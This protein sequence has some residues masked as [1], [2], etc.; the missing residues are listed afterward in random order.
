MAAAR[1]AAADLLG[2]VWPRAVRVPIHANI[3]DRR[4]RLCNNTMRLL[5]TGTA[6]FCYVFLFRSYL[7]QVEVIMSNNAWIDAPA[8]LPRVADHGNLCDNRDWDYHYSP[9]WG[10]V[11]N[12]CGVFSTA[13]IFSKGLPISIYWI[14]TY[15]VDAIT[16]LCDD[17]NDSTNAPA[18][19]AGAGANTRVPHRSVNTFV[20][21]VEDYLLT[22]DVFVEVPEYGF[23]VEMSRSMEVFI[24][25]P[26]TGVREQLDPDLHTGATVTMPLSKWL[27]L[28]GGTGIDDPF[29][30]AGSAS[31]VGTARL[32]MTGAGLNVKAEVTNVGADSLSAFPSSKVQLLL[33][34]TVSKQ[35]HR[36]VLLPAP[37]ARA[38]RHLQRDTY[39][40]RIHVEAAPSKVS[41]F[42][43]RRFLSSFFDVLIFFQVTTGLIRV[44]ALFALGTDSTRWRHSIRRHIDH[45]IVMNL[46]VHRKMELRQRQLLNDR[47]LM[48]RIGAKCLESVDPEGRLTGDRPAQVQAV[49]DFL[50][51]NHDGLVSVLEIEDL[52]DKLGV[53]QDEHTATHLMWALDPDGSGSLSRGEVGKLLVSAAGTTSGGASGETTTKRS[54]KKTTDVVPADTAG[55][56]MW[57]TDGRSVPTLTS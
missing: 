5:S 43:F 22:I 24:V 12:T 33:H 31:S 49:Y 39:G 46:D 3:T 44:F 30:E 6:V 34:V 40:F 55:L 28:A 4:V 2:I 42:H 19:C 41:V 1:A 57:Q 25:D 17:D 27:A 26:A 21:G 8:E 51:H 56:R 53:E 37:T 9:S 50:D 18:A 20:L 13:D 47:T 38:G 14:N 11:Y 7:T 29:P 32:R 16:D 54:K 48:S 36:R 23:T 35:W 52:L 45:H 10:Y 15:F